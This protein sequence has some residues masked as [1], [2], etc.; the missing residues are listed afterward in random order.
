MSKVMKAIAS[1]Y[2]NWKNSKDCYNKKKVK[3]KNE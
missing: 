2:V 3:E 1:G